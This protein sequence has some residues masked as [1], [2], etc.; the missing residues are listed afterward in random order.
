MA[1]WMVCRWV[2]DWDE[3][4]VMNF[5]LLVIHLAL[6]PEELRSKSELT[7]CRP[8]IVLSPNQND[9]L[10]VIFPILKSAQMTVAADVFSR[11][12]FT[13]LHMAQSFQWFEECPLYPWHPARPSSTSSPWKKQGDCECMFVFPSPPLP[14]TDTHI[15]PG[16]SHNV[17]WGKG[18]AVE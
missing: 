2:T 10:N 7:R 3:H 12:P 15:T 17:V 6:R 16:W 13:P 14:Q 5:R 1:C 8:F 18:G 4:G 9:I 11:L